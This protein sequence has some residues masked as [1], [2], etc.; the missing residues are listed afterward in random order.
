MGTTKKSRVGRGRRR[1]GRGR[2]R[3]R[4]D[5]ARTAGK[6]V[7]PLV[8]INKVVKH[9]PAKFKRHQ[10]DRVHRVKVRDGCFKRRDI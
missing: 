8:K 3:R 10:S 5:D 9:R 7:Q 2:T 1:R 4:E 6:M